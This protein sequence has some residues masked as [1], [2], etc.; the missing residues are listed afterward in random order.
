LS[1][2]S[3]INAVT[4]LDAKSIHSTAISP[5]LAR[6]I[7]ARSSRPCRPSAG[8]SASMATLGPGRI[9]SWVLMIAPLALIF[10]RQPRHLQLLSGDCTHFTRTGML[11]ESRCPQRCSI[12]FSLEPCR[13]LC[14]SRL[15]FAGI[16]N[17]P[18]VTARKGRPLPQTAMDAIRAV[19]C[20]PAAEPSS[21]TLVRDEANHAQGDSSEGPFAA[22]YRR[23]AVDIDDTW[24]R[25]PI[26]ADRSRVDRSDLYCNLIRTRASRS[27]CM[28]APKSRAD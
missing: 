21:F 23:T 18:Y 7:R 16:R 1:M 28:V 26:Y 9:P 2:V 15:G 12:A 6:T 22:A 11:V 5:G 19:A 27:P 10:S 20:A 3:V 4:P 13:S 8:T 14:C 25:R 24:A 17:S